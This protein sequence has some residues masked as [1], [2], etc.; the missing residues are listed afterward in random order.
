MT[1]RPLVGKWRVIYNA[2]QAWPVISQHKGQLQYWLAFAYQEMIK[3]L[4]GGP[5]QSARYF[6][7]FLIVEQ[8]ILGC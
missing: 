2:T 6:H 7:V 8:F 4:C 1:P 5:E 3:S